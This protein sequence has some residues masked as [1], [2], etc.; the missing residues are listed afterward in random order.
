M[1]RVE[2]QKTQFYA[3]SCMLSTPFRCHTSVINLADIRSTSPQKQQPTF[4]TQYFPLSNYCVKLDLYN[5]F[6]ISCHSQQFSYPHKIQTDTYAVFKNKIFL[7]PSSSSILIDFK[8]DS[9][10]EPQKIS[11]F[12]ALYNFYPLL[13]S[14]FCPFTL[15]FFSFFSLVSVF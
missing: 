5:E 9:Q 10:K 7:K 1:I 8:L 2:K 15:S 3:V 6:L 4:C 11:S 12:S 14:N 13:I